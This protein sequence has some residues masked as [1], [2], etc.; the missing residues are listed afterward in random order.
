MERREFLRGSIG[1]SAAFAAGA[2]AKKSSA[3]EQTN[4]FYAVIELMGFKRLAG[5]VTTGTPLWQIDIPVEG[6]FVTQFINPAT[7]I[8]RVTVTDEKSVREMSKGVDPL[9]TLTL[10]VPMT[11][12]RL[13]RDEFWDDEA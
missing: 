2:D 9:P 11:Q 8:Y 10:D 5:R 13:G 4:Q 6:G 3:G 1:A 12:P 7:S